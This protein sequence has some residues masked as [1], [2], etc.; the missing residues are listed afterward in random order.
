M[1]YLY[2]RLNLLD[3]AIATYGKAVEADP[4]S[5]TLGRPR[6]VLHG[7]RQARRSR[8]GH[9]QGGGR[10][11]ERGLLREPR[12]HAVAA[13]Q[14]SR[15][16]GGLPAGARDRARERRGPPQSRHP[17]PR[18]DKFAE[19]AESYR[20]ASELG[21][22]QPD[23]WW[24]LALALNKLQ[25][26]KEAEEAATNAIQSAPD[27]GRG[28]AERGQARAELGKTDEAL[29]DYLKALEK[30]PNDGGV[31]RDVGVT[32]MKT[33]R[34]EE[35]LPYL[36]RARDLGKIDIGPLLGECFL[37][38]KRLDES[39]AAFTRAVADLPKDPLALFGRAR[40][41]HEKGAAWR[42]S[43]TSTG[44]S[45]W[46]RASPRRSDSAA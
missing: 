18:Q 11:P 26:F 46:R 29:A 44:P 34:P 3:D 38:L 20:R 14:V 42:R 33:R 39:E 40:V 22:K 32:Y 21:C 19:A 23:G 27:S 15:G 10:A 12:R 1:G 8:E 28:Y 17:L 9:G 5:P 6:G 2:F 30:R 35:A 24:G 13:P 7:A 25:R 31:L 16:A 37:Q 4:K 45:R 43:R 36:Q 41:H